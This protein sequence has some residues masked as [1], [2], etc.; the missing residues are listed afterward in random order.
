MEQS[1]KDLIEALKTQK[2]LLTIDDVG[3]IIRQKKQTSYNQINNGKFPIKFMKLGGKIRI[4]PKD[5]AAY[6]EASFD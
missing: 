1:E 2:T 5:L 6:L 4:L 3:K